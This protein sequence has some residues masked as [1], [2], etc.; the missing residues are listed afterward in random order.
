MIPS[1]QNETTYHVFSVPKSSQSP[2]PEKVHPRYKSAR[3]RTTRR[4]K[5]NSSNN[6]TCGLG[7]FCPLRG[8]EPPGM[9][10]HHH[11]LRLYVHTPC[12]LP[13]LAPTT[14]H[15]LLLGSPVHVIDGEREREREAFARF[16]NAIR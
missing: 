9:N 12:H 1:L 14:R 8:N 2:Q 13:D 11:I 5:T 16:K 10:V 3:E 6:K 7:N 15:G 4:R